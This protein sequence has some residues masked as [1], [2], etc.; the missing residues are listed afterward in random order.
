MAAALRALTGR[1]V[2]AALRR[3][4]FEVVSIRGSHA[5]LRRTLGSGARQ[6]LTVPFHSDL[7]PGTLRAIYRQACRFVDEAE[8]RRAFFKHEGPRG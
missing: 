2:L 3:F 6:V 5:K 8:L 7:S 4:G 1:D